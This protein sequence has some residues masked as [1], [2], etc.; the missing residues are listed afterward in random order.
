[1]FCMFLVSTEIYVPEGFRYFSHCNRT[2]FV[3]SLLTTFFSPLHNLKWTSDQSHSIL[4]TIAPHCRVWEPSSTVLHKV[5]KSCHMVVVPHHLPR[6]K[7]HLS[8]SLVGVFVWF[9]FEMG[10]NYLANEYCQVIFIKY[11]TDPEHSS[12]LLFCGEIKR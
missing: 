5:I 10:E 11:K 9:C 4:N 6:D 12:R 8:V 3:W 1:M 7:L 2:R